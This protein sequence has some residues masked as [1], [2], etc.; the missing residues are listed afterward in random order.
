MKEGYE[1]KYGKEEAHLKGESVLWPKETM[2]FHF[3]GFKQRMQKIAIDSA[4]GEI[5]TLGPKVLAFFCAL[6]NH[7]L[8]T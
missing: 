8:R 1:K 7:G 5:S 2:D 4:K 6:L 3:I